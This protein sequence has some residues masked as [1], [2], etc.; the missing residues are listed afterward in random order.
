MMRLILSSYWIAF[1]SSTRGFAPAY[2]QRESRVRKTLPGRCSKTAMVLKGTFLRLINSFDGFAGDLTRFDMDTYTSLK[3]FACLHI[4]FEVHRPVP[5]RTVP[6]GSE[7]FYSY[8]DCFVPVFSILLSL[9]HY[10]F[11]KRL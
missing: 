11:S 4:Y 5:Y 10:Y 8:S 3:D 2:G 9:T 6:Y 7:G 1:S